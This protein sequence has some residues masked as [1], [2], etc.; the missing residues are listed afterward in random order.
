VGSSGSLL[1]EASKLKTV[2]V[3]PVVGLTLKA[4]VG[5]ALQV[6][7]LKSVDK[8]EVAPVEVVAVA[9]TFGPF[10]VPL[11]EKAPVAPSAVVA[12]S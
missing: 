10:G 6:P 12:P 11:Q 8:G 2:S 4:A 1:P 3:I 5:G 7:V 9:V